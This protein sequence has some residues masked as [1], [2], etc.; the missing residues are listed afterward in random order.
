MRRLVGIMAL[1]VMGLFFYGVN[2]YPLPGESIYHYESL[3]LSLTAGWLFFS[4][5]VKVLMIL[6]RKVPT[7]N[8]LAFYLA[9]ATAVVALLFR[10]VIEPSQ[11]EPLAMKILSPLIIIGWPAT[12]L[13]DLYWQEERERLAIEN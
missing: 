13:L 5:L 9:L 10:E 6:D 2:R 12:D 4:F 11:G 7:L 3:C 1:V 8:R